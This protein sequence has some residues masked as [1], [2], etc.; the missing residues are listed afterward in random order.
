MQSTFFAYTNWFYRARSLCAC[1]L[2]LFAFAAPLSSRAAN[3]NLLFTEL[4]RYG[5]GVLTQPVAAADLNNDGINDYIAFNLVRFGV[6]DGTFGPS[7]GFD[8]GLGGQIRTGDLTGD[9]QLEIVIPDTSA[10]KTLNVV[11]HP[12]SATQS[13]ISTPLGMVL[14]RFALVDFNGDGK[15]DVVGI[16]YVSFPLEGYILTAVGDGDG[17]FSS[18]TVEP[19]HPN[20]LNQYPQDIT[21]ADFNGDGRPDFAI[22]ELQAQVTGMVAVYANNGNGTFTRL[23][24]FG[25]PSV[26]SLAS[27]DFNHD[28]KAD[29][30][31][32]HVKPING[33]G[34]LTENIGV[35]FGNGDGTFGTVTGGSGTV[36]NQAYISGIVY[37]SATTQ[38]D[39]YMANNTSLIVADLTGDGQLDLAGLTVQADYPYTRRLAVLRGTA[40]GV[41]TLAKSLSL[42]AD[43][44]STSSN[45]PEIAV[46][47]INGDGSL[48]ILL[49]TAGGMYPLVTGL[50]VL[51]SVSFD[52][53]TNNSARLLANISGTGAPITRRGF[54]YATSAANPFPSLGDPSTSVVDDP[55][56][57]IGG[58][59]Q[60]VASL[61]PNTVYCFA[62]FAQSATGITHSPV[63]RFTT[64]PA[65]GAGS[66][67][68]TTLMDEANA[69]SDPALGTGTS[70]REAV[71]YANALGGAPT[72]T[73]SPNLFAFGPATITLTLGQITLANFSGTTTLRGPGSDLLTITNGGSS[74]QRM[75]RVTGP[76]AEI[77]GLRFH[78][79][80]GSSSGVAISNQVSGSFSLK[81][82]FFSNN[83]GDF[84]DGGALENTTAAKVQNCTFSANFGRSGGAI[85]NYAP[86]ILLNCTFFGNTA[87]G[88]SASGQGG[89]IYNNPINSAERVVA[90][91]CT[92]AANTATGSGGAIEIGNNRARIYNSLFAENT[93]PTA[94]DVS[95]TLLAGGNNLFGAVPAVVFSTAVLT[96]NG[97]ASPTLALKLSGPA[98]NAGSNSAAVDWT[99][100]TTATTT[101]LAND[102]H[103]FPR[104][105]GGTVDIGAFEAPAVPTV[106]N[107]FASAI[108]ASS[109]TVGAFVSDNGNSPVTE[110]GIVY[111]VAALNAN[112]TLGAVNVSLGLASLAANGGDIAGGIPSLNPVTQYAFAIYAVNDVGTAY[113]PVG[114]FTTASPPAPAAIPGIAP[115]SGTYTNN[116][117]V[118]LVNNAVGAALRYTIDGSTPSD[119]VGAL[120]TGPFT[121]TSSAT[122][123]VIATGGGWLP[124]G[125]VAANYTIQISALAAWR[126]L[127]GLPSD[128]SQDLANP[129]GDGVANLLKLA[130][131]MAP[132]AGDLASAN[133]SVLTPSG[134]SGLPLVTVDGSGRLV[135]TF[136]R[137][138]AANNPGLAYSV[139]TTADLAGEWP[140]L[141][142]AGAT[143]TGIDTAWER[144]SVTDPVVTARRFAR[145]RVQVVSP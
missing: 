29:L 67:V 2:A 116:V 123:K 84:I 94:N 30:A 136:V 106:I 12:G 20:Y 71:A 55:N 39:G 61:L 62:A 86:L 135:V 132:N 80:R 72:I 97:G 17:H 16:G 89:A 34:S 78:G 66:L 9:G 82:C 96:N 85:I 100:F 138:K 54:V 28:G 130:F 129:S 113:S 65:P 26:G 33:V 76:S 140:A 73:F 43:A 111:S 4:T 144:V 36:T 40:T 50:P 35:V 56:P 125:V 143:V 104:I 95:G 15:L 1:L 112:P 127:Q 32:T 142:L 42:P 14:K 64:S 41:F 3:P 77:S 7:H 44:S 87:I 5:V 63:F 90:V 101:P 52:S 38:L 11:M 91:N 83:G 47:E 92:F 120:Y 49:G 37:Y 114:T 68:V 131:K 53:V 103:G 137:L 133:T 122:V 45:P 69:S 27:G 118:T 105:V 128:G 19:C 21:V 124:S 115:E 74:G 10:S 119:V 93:A 88:D 79:G 145:V 23:R 99:S 48:D 51:D 60:T 31:F 102:Q 8:V 58:Y 107:P 109:A 57:G 141:D 117:T 13:I 18:L 24:P 6:G 46:A 98:I 70:L 134:V 121:L 110:V 22:T 75:L 139:E 81:D 25:V 126:A 108:T 59:G